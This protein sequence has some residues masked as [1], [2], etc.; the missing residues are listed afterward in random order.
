MNVS[1]LSVAVKGES[2]GLES[3]PGSLFTGKETRKKSMKSE[4]NNS[5]SNTK[6]RQIVAESN[7]DLHD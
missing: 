2:D 5:S 1:R 4:S 7:F 3:P 6:L